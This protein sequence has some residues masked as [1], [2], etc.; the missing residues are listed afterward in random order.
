M[1][2]KDPERRRAAGREAQERYR[3]RHPDRVR[4]YANSEQG[5]KSRAAWK[6]RNVEKVRAIARE[7]QRR[8]RQ[9]QRMA[10]KSPAL[11]RMRADLKACYDSATRQ[12]L[13]EAIAHMEKVIMGGKV[14]PRDP[15]RARLRAMPQVPFN[16]GL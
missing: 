5:R 13:I 11:D 6:A 9:A 7:A 8:K 4:A 3:R 16:A 15:R 2:Y 1:P 10:G 14:K 12:R